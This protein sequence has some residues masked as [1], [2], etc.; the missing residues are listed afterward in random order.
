MKWSAR[1]NYIFSHYLINGAIFDEYVTEHT[2]CVSIFSTSFVRNVSHSKKKWARYHQKCAF[3]IT[4]STNYSCQI[5]TNL[6]F[7]RQTFEKYEHSVLL[8]KLTTSTYFNTYVSSSG[9]IKTRCL[10][11][12][13]LNQNCVRQTWMG[14][15][16]IHG[17]LTGHEAE[18]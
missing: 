1:P 2:M 9:D 6:S 14:L 11:V 18:K 16:K 13:L 8:T 12:L 17:S 7:S 15:S 10:S 3:A 5:L 4:W